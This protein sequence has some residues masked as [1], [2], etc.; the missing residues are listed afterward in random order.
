MKY[1]YLAIDDDPHVSNSDCVL[2]TP[3]K[4]YPG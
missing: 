4:V 3:G 1:I 2:N